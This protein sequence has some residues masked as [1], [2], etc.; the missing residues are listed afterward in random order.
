MNI[1]T[2]FLKGLVSSKTHEVEPRF[3]EEMMIRVNLEATSEEDKA[4]TILQ[5]IEVLE[6]EIKIKNQ[7][8]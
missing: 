4:T 6:K 5:V 8:T 1:L 3:Y 7:T 2:K